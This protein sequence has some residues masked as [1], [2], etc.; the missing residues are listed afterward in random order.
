M[1]FLSTEEWRFFILKYLFSDIFSI[2]QMSKVKHWI[3]NISRTL[4]Q[5]FPNLATEMYNY[6][7]R[8][9]IDSFCVVAMSTRLAPAP[10]CEKPYIPE[11]LAWN[12]YGSHLALTLFIT[13]LGLDDPCLRQHMGT[14]ILRKTDPVA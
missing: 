7:S 1:D 13:L 3:E 12:T 6:N 10:F 14:R 11:G 2:M 4:Q 5:C 9:Q 8:K